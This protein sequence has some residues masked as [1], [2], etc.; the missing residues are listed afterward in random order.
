[1][2]H[3]ELEKAYKRYKIKVTD[4]QISN[5]L[6]EVDLKDGTSIA[7]RE[8]IFATLSYDDLIKSS[9]GKMLIE[10]IFQKF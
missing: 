8:F 5:I 2:S 4:E 6:K 3:V 10:N 7:K 1:L 9:E